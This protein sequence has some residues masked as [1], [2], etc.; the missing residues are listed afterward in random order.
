VAITDI[1]KNDI[2][3]NLHLELE[4]NIAI[5]TEAMGLQFNR[6]RLCT[7]QF[8]D[9]NQKS[10]I[11]QFEKGKYNAPNLA[12]VLTDEKR[13]KIFH[14]ARFDIAIIKHYLDIDINN[15]FCTK[16]ASRLVR[17]YTDSHG[18]KELCK[19]LL[20]VQMSKQQQSSDWGSEVFSKDQQEY[21]IN[22]VVHLHKLRDI[23]IRM[24]LR[25]DR[26]EIAKKLFAFLPTRAELDLMGWCEIDIFAHS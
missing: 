4:G 22:D 10:Y 2:P 11:V 25:E 12:K 15:I 7:V 14:F 18:L 1:F 8:C 23:L 21:A 16:I 3:E 20:S 19:E 24:L 6:D 9:E 26:M 13:V 17:T 5:D